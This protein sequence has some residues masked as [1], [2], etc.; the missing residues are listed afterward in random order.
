MKRIV[1]ATAA[2]LVALAGP[3]AGQTPEGMGPCE[4]VTE[5]VPTPVNVELVTVTDTQ[6][7]LTWLTCAAGKPEPADSQVTYE[8]GS[9]S[10]VVK[11]TKKTPFHWVL[12]DDLEP[13][14]TY[15]YTVSSGGVPAP[16]ERLNP[17]L[18]T[19]L[20]PPPGK[21]LLRVAVLADIHIGEKRSGL[22]T[23]QP[24][25]FPPAYS[26]ERPYPEVML[27]GAVQDIGRHK[28]SLTLL[29]ADNSSHGERHDLETARRLLQ[30]L[31]RYLIARG[32][33][34]RPDQY[35]AAFSEC[36]PD[37]DCFRA[38]FRPGVIPGDEPQHL[39]QVKRVRGWTFVGLDSVNLSSGSGSLS[40]DQL[41]WLGEQLEIAARRES[42]VVVFFHHPVSEYSTTLA[43]P[44][45]I[46][47]VPQNE[48][49]AF[50][51]LIDGYDV[52]LVINAHTHRNWISYSPFTGRTP[53][54]EVGPS[55]EYPGG[56]SIFRIY[57]GGILREWWP[58]SCGFCRMWRETTRGEYLSLYPLYTQGSLRDRAWVHRFDRPDVPHVPSLPLGLWPSVIPGEA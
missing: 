16:P 23:S 57:E 42:P 27:T 50:L 39:P 25:E 12:L 31:G 51:R 58:T 55:K 19:T 8:S 34:D 26:S 15:R 52:R 38:V 18:F 4:R 44:P 5:R 32:S 10:G 37:S 36:A 47:G 40:A 20:T 2:A 45:A 49:N 43:V 48:A 56:Y 9:S 3:V 53:I 41:E 54:V 14:T 7:V 21:E 22:A 29:P 30:P 24:F 1:A 33:H 11:R 13:G 35:T 28:V 46:F 17:G 6:A